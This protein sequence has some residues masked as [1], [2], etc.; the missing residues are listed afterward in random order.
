MWSN[1]LLVGFSDTEDRDAPAVVVLGGGAE[2]VLLRTGTFGQAKA[3]Q[4]RFMS[5]LQDVGPKTFCE[6]YSLPLALVE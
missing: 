5:E 6:R 2:V 1:I 3:A 4:R